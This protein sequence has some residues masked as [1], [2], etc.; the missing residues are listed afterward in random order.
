MHNF[1]SKVNILR[2]NVLGGVIC[3]CKHPK[4]ETQHTKKI[5]AQFHNSQ[6]PVERKEKDFSQVQGN[7]VDAEAEVRDDEIHASSAKHSTSVT[8]R[9]CK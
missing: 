2:I 9:Q 8:R 6:L 7:E 5:Q 4:D 3:Y 1:S